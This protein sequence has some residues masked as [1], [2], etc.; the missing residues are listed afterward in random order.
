VRRVVGIDALCGGCGGEGVIPSTEHR[1]EQCGGSGSAACPE[2]AALIRH[3]EEYRDAMTRDFWAYGQRAELAEKKLAIALP[4][5]Q[6]LA[7][8][9]LPPD[10]RVAV[11]AF[12]AIRKVNS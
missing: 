2:R 7:F 10:N 12:D 3:H 8:D 5:L 9:E 4:A 11:D 1:C 6:S